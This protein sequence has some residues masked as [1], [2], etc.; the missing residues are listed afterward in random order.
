[1]G[2]SGCCC[3]SR[4]NRRSYVLEEILIN[5]VSDDVQFGEILGHLMDHENI[6][7]HVE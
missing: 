7:E 3:G 1:M 5:K 2:N 6:E 4:N